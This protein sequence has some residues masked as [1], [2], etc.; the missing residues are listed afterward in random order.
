LKDVVYDGVNVAMA[1]GEKSELAVGGSGDFGDVAGRRADV[2]D[3][4]GDT[5]DV[6]D[7]AGMNEANK[8]IAHDDD[9]EVGG[10]E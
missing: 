1:S 9:V 6:I 5:E 2:E 4:S 8:G 7:F 10:R 3:R